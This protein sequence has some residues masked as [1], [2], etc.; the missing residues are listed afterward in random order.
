MTAVGRAAGAV[1]ME[2]R[3]QFRDM[4]GIMEGTSGPITRARST[5]SPGPRSRR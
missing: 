3:R 4:P 2:V 5:C 1:V